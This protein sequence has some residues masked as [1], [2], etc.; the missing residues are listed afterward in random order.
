MPEEEKKEQQSEGSQM[1][2]TQV[3]GGPQM[4]GVDT[5]TGKTVDTANDPGEKAPPAA[6]PKEEPINEEPAKEGNVDPMVPVGP[7]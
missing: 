7:N 3:P 1:P 6:T 2:G 4:P 5:A